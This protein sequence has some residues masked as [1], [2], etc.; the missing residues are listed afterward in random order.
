[1]REHGPRLNQYFFPARQRLPFMITMSYAHT[2]VLLPTGSMVSD[3]YIASRQRRRFPFW[4]TWN[5]LSKFQRYVLYC[6]VLLLTL[7]AV[8]KFQK[9][10]E[11]MKID[12]DSDGRLHIA[13]QRVQKPIETEDLGKHQR[14]LD[15]RRNEELKLEQERTGKDQTAAEEN[16]PEGVE[17]LDIDQENG[18]DSVGGGNGAE[19]D[20]RPLAR[21][22]ARMSTSARLSTI[23]P[24]F[25]QVQENMVV[26]KPR[27]FAGAANYRQKQVVEAFQWAYDAYKKYA[28]G[29]DE[30]KPM[31][32]SYKEWFKVGLTLV[33]SLDTM[34]IMGLTKEFAEAQKWVTESL[35]FD[36]NVDVNLF[37]ITIRVLGGLLSAYHLSGDDVFKEKSLDLGER[38]LVAFET[39]S[40]VPHSDVNLQKKTSHAPSWGPD[41]STAEVTTIQLEFNDLSFV[42]GDPK[43]ATKSFNVAEIVHKLP[44]KDGLVPIF[45]NAVTGHFRQSAVISF[46]ARGDSYYEYLLK[47]WL[48][49]GKRSDWLRDDYVQAITGAQK[50]LMRSSLPNHLVFL[51]ELHGPRFSS[52]MDVLA[53]FLPGTLALGYMNGMPEDHLTLAQN[54]AY[55]CRQMYVRTATGLGPEIGHFNIGNSDTP[56]DT[57]DMYIKTNDAH[58]LLRPEYVESLFYLYRLTKNSTYQEWGWDVFL[59]IEKYAKVQS[60]GYA[61]IENVNEAEKVR[62]RDHMESFL[63]AETFK[64]LF[65]LFDDERVLLPLDGYVFN[66][67]AH[68]LPIR[69]PFVSLKP[70]TTLT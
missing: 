7:L 4:R 27:I 47:Q 45:I 69:K 48:Q 11:D 18:N 43:F 49:D 55:T 33:D 10:G 23:K 68:P 20:T 36:K 54:L 1:M 70:G 32:K 9:Y 44:K 39:E 3:N 60:G 65:L 59:A 64:Y 16:L 34:Y 62:H 29:H 12:V 26:P 25:E 57:V 13:R 6:A 5:R 56:A 30:L 24:A 14:Y 61:S 22:K 67:E 63:L 66:T 28:W 58:A 37:E 46:G 51:G 42:T 15:A 50:H 2:S 53:C 17:P 21:K 38:L 41:S 52:K 35:T 31:S 40:G 8:T 19:V